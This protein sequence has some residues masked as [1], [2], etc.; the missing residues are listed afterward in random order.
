M[1]RL[2]R[3][4][5]GLGLFGGLLALGLYLG[6]RVQTD[7]GYVLFAYAG[8]TVEMSLWTFVIVFIALSVMLW[9]LFG[10][11]QMLGQA[12]LSMWRLFGR[13]RH[14]RA[15]GRL[16]EGALWLRRDAPK[17]AL[18]VLKKDANSESLPA[19]HWLLASE[20]ARRNE[21]H[22][23]SEAYLAKAEQ[24]IPHVPKPLPVEHPPTEFK[25]LMKSLKKHWREDWALLLES[26]G[27]EDALTRLSQLTALTQQIQSSVSLEI[28]QA[29]LALRASL[30]A[31]AR[32]HIERAKALD[33]D[34]PLVLLLEIEKV[35]GTS[36]A[37]EHMRA[38][39]IPRVS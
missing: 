22:A 25:T 7:P 21:E 39:Y 33:P 29:R 36:D 4:L 8:V 19:L 28:V 11:G 37:L 14:R 31:E 26:V 10:I 30:E 2:I 35:A 18:D 38:Q 13:A 34:H 15:D 17:R 23:V 32:H 24:L 16:I 20:A 5:I 3:L 6:E 27:S 1:S 12:P 9:I